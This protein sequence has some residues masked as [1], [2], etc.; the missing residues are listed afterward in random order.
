MRR[1]ARSA[2]LAALTLI[3]VLAGVSPANAW[4]SRGHARIATAA[5]QTLPAS[6]PGFFRDGAATIGEAAVDPDLWK[7]D[8]RP[9]LLAVEDPQH[10]LNWELLQGA[11]LPA[12]RRA[13]QALLIGKRLDDARGGMLPYAVL[14]G[15]QRLTVAFAEHRRWPQRADIQ[16]KALVYAGWLAHYAGD[17][18]QPLHT[19]MHH[20]G[21]TRP[22]GTSP[23]TGIHQLVDALLERSPGS[24]T[25]LEHGIAPRVF[26]DPWAAIQGE[27]AESH[28]LVDRVY[29]LE[30]QLRAPS[31]SRAVVAFAAERYRAATGFVASLFLTA[32]KQSANAQLPGW[33]ERPSAPQRSH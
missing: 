6:V 13:Y 33:L 26:L 11:S 5:A 16:Q 28:A 23:Q 19:T 18:E 9:A 31:P 32:W 30:P 22:D 29:Q 8:A 2:S 25:A 4:F 20:D 3:A 17:V 15:M 14:E 24:A 1:R 7:S 21:R 27:L 12:D 10:F